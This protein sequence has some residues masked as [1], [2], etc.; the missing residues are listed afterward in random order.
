MKSDQLAALHGVLK[1]ALYIVLIILAMYLAG[2]LVEHFLS[3]LSPEQVRFRTLRLIVRFA[4]RAVGLVL[5]LLVVFGVPDQLTT[6]LGLAGAGLTV[7]LQDF[8]IS[9][10][11]WFALMGRNGIRV[12][13]GW[14][15]TAWPA[16]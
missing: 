2:V 6:V 16:K 8:I 4:L 14:K 5:I 12:G 1:S 11:G 13:T 15:S 10:L 7:A 3:D 9:F